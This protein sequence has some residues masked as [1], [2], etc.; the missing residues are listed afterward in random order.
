LWRP[1]FTRS[2]HWTVPTCKS[3]ASQYSSSQ[4]KRRRTPHIRLSAAANSTYLH[5]LSISPPPATRG[6]NIPSDIAGP[7][8]TLEMGRSR[9]P[10]R[11]RGSTMTRNGAGAW[12]GAVEYNV[13]MP[14]HSVDLDSKGFWRWCITIIITWFLDFL[15]RPVL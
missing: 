11:M 15:H 1:R 12:Y 3:A 4:F 9:F 10:V 14:N 2:F 8:A 5:L 7:E 6:R 13:W